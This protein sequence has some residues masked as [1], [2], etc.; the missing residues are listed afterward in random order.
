MVGLCVR[1]ERVRRAAG[2]SDQSERLGT[3]HYKAVV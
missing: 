1:E 3:R 2:A